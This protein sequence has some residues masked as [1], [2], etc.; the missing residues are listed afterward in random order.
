MLWSIGVF[1][2]PIALFYKCK[3]S[4]FQP[5]TPKISGLVVILIWNFKLSLNFRIVWEDKCTIPS[6]LGTFLPPHTSHFPL[7]PSQL[8][9]MKNIYSITNYY[10]KGLICISL[11]C[12][13]S[14]IFSSLKNIV[15]SLLILWEW[16]S[17]RLWF[18]ISKPQSVCIWKTARWFKMVLFLMS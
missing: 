2:P 9:G 10:V 15:V 18:S 12:S 11:H 16:I 4:T 1:S 8:C 13:F 6:H 3:S 14:L 5:F 17:L 7:F